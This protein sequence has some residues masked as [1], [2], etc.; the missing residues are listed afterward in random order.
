[1]AIQRMRSS[2]SSGE[3]SWSCSTISRASRSMSGWKKR[4][5]RLT[6]SAPTASRRLTK[7]GSD[8]KKGG[9]FMTTGTLTVRLSS[10]SSAT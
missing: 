8:E 9:S 3:E 4:L 1:M 10:A 6:P 2:A 7:W 5:N